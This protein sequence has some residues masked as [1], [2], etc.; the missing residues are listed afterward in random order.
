MSNQPKTTT[1]PQ[2]KQQILLELLQR[3]EGATIEQIMHE[4][5]WQ[6]HSVR[7][8]LSG[9][10]KKKLGLTVLSEKPKGGQR[11]YRVTTVVNSRFVS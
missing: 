5:G 6:S 8:V 3:P 10:I 2:T 4:T 11:A 1:K 7:G 9:V